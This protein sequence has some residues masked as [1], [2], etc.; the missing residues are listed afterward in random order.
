V[1]EGATE[2]LLDDATELDEVLEEMELL[3]EDDEVEEELVVVDVVVDVEAVSKTAAAPA[4]TIIT[5]ITTMIA[6]LLIPLKVRAFFRILDG[7]N[8]SALRVS[9]FR[10]C[11]HPG[12]QCSI[13]KILIRFSQAR[14]FSGLLVSR[15]RISTIIVLIGGIVSRVTL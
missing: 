3:D 5:T 13:T 14:I 15:I 10:I 9:L 11:Y 7:D 4:T 1:L 6:I 12:E 2:L 8:K